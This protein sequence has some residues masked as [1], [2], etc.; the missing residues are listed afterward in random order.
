[1]ASWL[2]DVAGVDGVAHR[3]RLTVLDQNGS[4]EMVL[5][6]CRVLGFSASFRFDRLFIPGFIGGCRLVMVRYGKVEIP[7]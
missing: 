3:F 4:G 6:N 7:S 1:M 2:K 5:K